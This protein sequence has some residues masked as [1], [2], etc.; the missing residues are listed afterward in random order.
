MLTSCPS[1]MYSYRRVDLP[2]AADPGAADP[3]GMLCQYE[4]LPEALSGH[5]LQVCSAWKV[6]VDVRR[7]PELPRRAIGPPGSL[8]EL[9]RKAVRAPDRLP[10]SPQSCPRPRQTGCQ[11][12]G[13]AR[14]AAQ[15]PCRAVK[16]RCRGA[17]RPRLRSCCQA[18]WAASLSGSL[19]GM[20]AEA[21]GGLAEAVVRPDGLPACQ[22]ACQEG[23]PNARREAGSP[24]PSAGS[25]K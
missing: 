1:P 7:L 6:G 19:S 14:R 9:P 16:K 13:S 5:Y 25:T 20:A 21:S 10:R 12:C 17:K 4:G 2:G 23:P 22:A 15:R 3:V 24:I 18:R 8:A 11:S